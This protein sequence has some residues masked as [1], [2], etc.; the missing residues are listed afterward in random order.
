MPRRLDRVARPCNR[1]RVRT[2][3]IVDDDDD[4]R[5]VIEELFALTTHARA[6]S[7]AGLADVERLAA[8]AL[9]CSIAILDINLGADQPSGIDV[10][11]WLKRHDFSGKVVFLTGHADNHP[12][13][14]VASKE[15]GVR[16]FKK[17]IEVDQLL[18][19]VNEP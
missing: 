4:L 12:L 10:F 11:N 9:G 2:L 7:A 16:V 5:A 8:A 1:G 15:S 19:L 3:L 18:D 17:P 6:V 13:V 14:K